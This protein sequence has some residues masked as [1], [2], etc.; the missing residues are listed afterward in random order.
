MQMPSHAP[1]TKALSSELSETVF[2]LREPHWVF[3]ALLL[4]KKFTSAHSEDFLQLLIGPFERFLCSSHHH[5][6]NVR[7]ILLHVAKHCR[8]AC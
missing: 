4:R 3:W 8:K 7:P 6:I 2:W 1:A 5:I